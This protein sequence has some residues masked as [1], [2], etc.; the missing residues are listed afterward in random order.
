MAPGAEMTYGQGGRRDEHQLVEEAPL[1]SGAEAIE[2]L[3]E[4]IVV[5]DRRVEAI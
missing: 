4:S 5:R 3:R 1:R 2:R